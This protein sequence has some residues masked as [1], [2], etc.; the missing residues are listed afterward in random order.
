MCI[1]IYIYIYIYTHVIIVLTHVMLRA[2]LREPFSEILTQEPGPRATIC[3]FVQLVAE[4]LCVL[5]LHWRAW[6][7]KTI[8]VHLWLVHTLRVPYH[9]P[10]GFL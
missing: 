5:F 1:Y 3:I 7:S 9:W 8:S 4:A 6:P 10:P 2:S